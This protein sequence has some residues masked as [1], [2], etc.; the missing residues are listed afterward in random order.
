VQG[1]PRGPRDV[2]VT[3]SVEVSNGEAPFPRGHIDSPY[4]LTVLVEEED[5][6]LGDEVQVTVAFGVQGRH[7]AAGVGTPAFQE[8][9]GREGPIPEPL[10][11]PDALPALRAK[12]GH[13]IQEPVAAPIGPEKG[14]QGLSIA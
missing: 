14:A 8:P 10:K 9:R 13:E 2:L 11:K 3:I 5:A 12:E 6:C 4:E 1:Q 7:G